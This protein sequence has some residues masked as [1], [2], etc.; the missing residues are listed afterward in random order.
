MDGDWKLPWEGGC[1]CGEV[2]YT[3]A[4]DEMPATYACHCHQ[5]QRWSGSAFSQ[6]L[7]VLEDM[8]SVTGPIVTFEK[9][10]EDRTS[11]QRF[12]GTCHCRI[13]NTNTR[14]PGLAVV[15]A[16]TLDRS[17]ECDCVAHIFTA[18]KQRWFVL[19]DGVPSWPEMAPP[20]AMRDLLSKHLAR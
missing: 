5:C 11:T 2:R 19:P 10:T 15:R 7:F 3:L 16:G 18:T 13:Y 20:E 1:R 6:N 8:L 12:C 14:R 4:L 17:E 9:V